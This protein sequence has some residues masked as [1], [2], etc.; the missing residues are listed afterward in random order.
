MSC[1]THAISS[2]VWTIALDQGKKDYRNLFFGDFVLIRRVSDIS[3]TKSIPSMETGI[4]NDP[5]FGTHQAEDARTLFENSFGWR[6]P[7]FSSA[8]KGPHQDMHITRF[9]LH[10]AEELS[11][12]E[13][14]QRLKRNPLVALTKKMHSNLVFSF[15]RDHGH[16]GRILNQIVVVEPSIEVS[17]NRVFGMA[18]TPQDGNSLLSSTAATLYF[19]NPEKYKARME[20]LLDF[21]LVFPIL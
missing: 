7:I 1:N 3:Q 8:L 2:I 15:G 20:V 19:L 16:C 14:L 6:L 13:V 4:H 12:E 21:P 18:Y 10:L 11:R 17:S 5:V 9:N